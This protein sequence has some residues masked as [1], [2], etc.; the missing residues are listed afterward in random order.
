LAAWYE[1][2]VT[3]TPPDPADRAAPMAAAPF[4]WR[5]DGRP[6]WGAMWTSFCELALHGG[7]PHR[8]AAQALRGAEAAGDGATSDAAV[9]AEIRRGIWETTGLYAEPASPGWVALTCESPGMAEWLAAAI[10]LENVEARAE[11]DRLLL[12]AGPRFRLE[13]EVKSV[14]TV[15]AKTHHFGSIHGGAAREPAP[16][17]R[18]TRRLGFRC[19]SC[20][21]DCQVSRPETTADL[22]ATCPVD[23]TL[24]TR[25]GA[26]TAPRLPGPLRV[27]IEGPA[28]ARTALIDALRRRYG[29]RRVVV[30]SAPQPGAV[31]DHAVGLV[32]VEGGEAAVDATVVI[33]TAGAAT[34]DPARIEPDTGWRPIVFVDLSAAEGIDVV[35]SWLEREL[36]FT[37]WR[38]GR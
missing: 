24:L 15:V 33:G 23:G 10:V 31:T 19:V 25:L 32:L 36:G 34:V 38:S 16:R 30:A 37:P 18:A 26:V 5:E 22:D 17:D 21:L 35:A 28:D 14:I 20:G 1:S 11:G 2:S 29:R 9:T 4:V 27:G 3:S 13:N 7:P 8:G 12:P 6:D